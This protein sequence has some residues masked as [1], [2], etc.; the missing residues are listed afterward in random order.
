MGPAQFHKLVQKNDDGVHHRFQTH[1]NFVF[2]QQSRVLIKKLSRPYNPECT[3][4]L[5][6]VNGGRLVEAQPCLP[7]TSKEKI[8]PFGQAAESG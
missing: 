7:A 6:N 1:S 8:K 2:V 3:D 5:I 4:F